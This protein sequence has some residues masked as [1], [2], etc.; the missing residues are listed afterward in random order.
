MEIKNVEIQNGRKPLFTLDVLA[1]MNTE[2]VEAELKALKDN[3]ELIKPKKSSDALP[4]TDTNTNAEAGS[5]TDI[6]Q[7]N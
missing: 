5:S 6:K 3:S 2:E 4:V 7:D 1:N